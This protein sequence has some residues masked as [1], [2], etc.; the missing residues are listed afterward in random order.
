MQEAEDKLYALKQGTDS[1]YAYV[2]KFKQVLY[3]ARGQNWPDV[4]K[5]STFR[6]SLNTTLR[7]RLA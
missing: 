7:N 5:I 3:E 6:N 4:N 2:A 1:L